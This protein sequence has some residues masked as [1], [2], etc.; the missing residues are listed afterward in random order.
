MQL[1]ERLGSNPIWVPNLGMPVGF[2]RIVMSLNN[3]SSMQGSQ[4]F[5][6]WKKGILAARFRSRSFHLGH[7][8]ES[9]L[10]FMRSGTGKFLTSHS[11]LGLDTLEC[12]RLPAYQ[13]Q[14]CGD[15]D[16]S[17]APYSDR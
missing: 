10:A 14:L 5:S 17:P 13:L 11:A 3:L 9:M 8:F 4:L 12:R 15:R 16:F 7:P 2:A 1:R 6:Y